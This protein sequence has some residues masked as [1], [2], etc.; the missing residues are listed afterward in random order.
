VVRRAD[1]EP[2]WTAEP[3]LDRVLA[4]TETKTVWHPIGV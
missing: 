4:F 1:P 3:A 2:D